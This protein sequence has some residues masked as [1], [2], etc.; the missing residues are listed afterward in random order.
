MSRSRHIVAVAE[1]VLRPLEALPAPVVGYRRD[2][3]DDDH[4]PPHHHRRAQLVFASR[5]VMTVTAQGRAFVVPP[6]RGVWVPG[7]VQHAVAA[8]GAVSMRTLY[9]EPR[10]VPDLPPDVAVLQVTPLLR[11]LILAIVQGDQD[12]ASDSA[13]ARMAAVILDQI[14][15]LPTAPLSLPVP[16]EPRLGRV[17]AGLMADPADPRDLAAWAHEAGVSERTLARLFTQHTGMSFRAWRQQ[18]RLLRALELLAGGRPVTT[19]ALELG[20]DSTSAFS[21]MFRRALGTTPSAYFTD[22]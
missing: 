10:E 11:E 6:L 1:A 3:D 14:R 15:V 20:Y 9:I 16:T 8:H 13:P 5:G 21:A 2:L 7:G 12:Y 18:R 22:G 19:V 17:T 4:I